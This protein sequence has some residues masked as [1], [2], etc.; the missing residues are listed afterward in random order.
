MAVS[1]QIIRT[2]ST[3]DERGYTF[4][5][6]SNGRHAHVA[7]ADDHTPRHDIYHAGNSKCGWCYLGAPHSE[8]EHN[9]RMS[10]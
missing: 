7:D 10:M 4:T 9:R 5:R 6:E 1:E 2:R 3:T 8:R